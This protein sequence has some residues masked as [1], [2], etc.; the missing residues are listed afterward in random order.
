MS[1]SGSQIDSS[2]PGGLIPGIG[3]WTERN[4]AF[5]L[6]APT[7]AAIALVNLYPLL[8]TI[9][10]SFHRWHIIYPG[11]PFIGLKNY[12]NALGDASLLHS[13]YISL[14]W[15]VAIVAFTYLLGL[16]IALLFNLK[17]PGR[18]LARALIIIPWALPNFV[19]A[20]VWRWIMNDQYGILTALLFQSGLVHQKPVWFGPEL[21]LF[22]CILVGIWKNL[23]F[24]IIVLLAGLQA[25]PGFLYEA[26]Y[27]DGANRWQ[28][29][30]KITL[31]MI[32]PVSLTAILL[33]AINLFKAFELVWLL[34]QGGPGEA[35]TVFPIKIYQMG[36]I[37]GR[38]GYAAA[39]AMVLFVITLVLCG[40]YLRS[41]IR[42]M[43]E[44]GI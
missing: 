14:V 6:V 15:T 42:E 4:I 26:A 16:A 9:W 35:T 5:V 21:A 28:C 43:K 19:S 13:I 44:G 36:F 38:F 17:F 24:M 40:I 12:Q 3:R 8:Y 1:V 32:K 27:M 2:L 23:P 30:C 31:P 29:F 22:S 37:A 34:T 25:I 20:L 33:T 10:L 11:R 39:A 7:L 18:S 41:Y